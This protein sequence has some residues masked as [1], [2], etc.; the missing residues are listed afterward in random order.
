MLWALND[1]NNPHAYI[2]DEESVDSQKYKLVF[3]MT[4]RGPKK[5]ELD[6]YPKWAQNQILTSI[7]A[8]EL[9]NTA[10]PKETKSKKKTGNKRK[11]AD[12]G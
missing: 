4:D 12:K 1:P 9:I 10:K 2:R 11:T 3:T 7:R 6:D 5:V 8:G